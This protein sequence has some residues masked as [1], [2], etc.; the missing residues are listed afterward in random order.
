MY[1][2]SIEAVGYND[3]VFHRT[4]P[5][6]SSYFGIGLKRHSVPTA[7]M[8]RFIQIDLQPHNSTKKQ[9]QQQQKTNKQTNKK[10]QNTYTIITSKML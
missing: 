3:G 10:G 2:N 1:G 6:H 4:L 9:Q 5:I 7:I 8:S